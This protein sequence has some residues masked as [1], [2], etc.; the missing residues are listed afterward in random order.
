MEKTPIKKKFKIKKAIKNSLIYTLT[1]D[2]L[3]KTHKKINNV[4]KR[5]KN[6][7]MP[8][9]PILKLK[10]KKGIQDTLFTNWKEPTDLLKKT[11][12]N[13]ELRYVMQ[14]TFKANIF[15]AAWL[16]EDIPNNN[17][18]PIKGVTRVKTSRLIVFDKKKSDINIL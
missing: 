3:I 5:I 15:N 18:A 2:Q 9:I 7:D 6:K 1:L 10:F 12:K 17:K 4:V 11:H 13:K 8:S 14:E 16:E